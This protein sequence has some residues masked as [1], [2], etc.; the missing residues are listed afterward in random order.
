MTALIIGLIAAFFITTNPSKADFQYYIKDSINRGAEQ[1]GWLMGAVLKLTSGL[2]SSA[3]EYS[4]YR[5]D[6]LFFSVYETDLM[7]NR[8]V[9]IGAANSFVRI[10]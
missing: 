4:T 3:I 7:G 1:E 8:M 5:R 10:E 2:T 6:Y 9:F